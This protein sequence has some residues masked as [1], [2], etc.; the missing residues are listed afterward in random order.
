M[1]R[2]AGGFPKVDFTLG[3]CTFCGECTSEC[4][5]GLFERVRDP[6]NPGWTHRA[7]VSERCLTNV[8]VMCRSCEDACEPAAIRFRLAAGKVPAPVIEDQACTGCGACIR[9]CPETAISMTPL[10]AIN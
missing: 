6:E 9:R 5:A 2:G 10:E 3:E 4:D 1:S 7:V 8:G